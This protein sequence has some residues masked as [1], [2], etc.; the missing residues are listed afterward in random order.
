MKAM[1]AWL[2]ITAL[3]SLTACTPQAAPSPE[4]LG[5]TPEATQTPVPTETIVWFPPTPTHTLIPT[6]IVEPTPD[7]RPPRGPELL[8]DDFSDA[9]HWQVSQTTS[10]SIAYGHNELTLAVRQP[11]TALT[12]L[13][14][15]PELGDFYLEITTQASLCRG[16]DMYGLLLRAASPDDYYRF[17]INCNGETRLERIVAGRSLPLMDWTQRGTIPAGSPVALRIGVL[18]SGR[19]LSFFIDGLEQFTFSDPVHSS[20]TVGVFV[21]STGDTALTVSFSDLVVTALLPENPDGAVEATPTAESDCP[22][23]LYTGR[24]RCEES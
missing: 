23:D 24:P 19:E 2:L 5:K 7:P 11:K 1:L 20:G 3:A 17:L 18:A 12:S 4:V 8:V 6:I 21:R 13:R 15:G 9:G 10:G 16:A 14:D 22:L